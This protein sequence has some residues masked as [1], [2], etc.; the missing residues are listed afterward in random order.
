[1][2]EPKCPCPIEVND[3]AEPIEISWY[4]I[5]K[6]IT[7]E[8]MG[9]EAVRLLTVTVMAVFRQNTFSDLG[10]FDKD[11]NVHNWPEWVK[12]QFFYRRDQLSVILS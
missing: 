5:P 9:S 2:L 8:G 6:G 4:A 10:P 7:I 12:E 11:N 3:S 1:M